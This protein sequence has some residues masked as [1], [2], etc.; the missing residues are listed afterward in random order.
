MLF[1]GD[2]VHRWHSPFLTGI[3][4]TTSRVAGFVTSSPGRAWRKVRVGV[5]CNSIIRL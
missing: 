5:H 3:A 1:E 2:L 4:R